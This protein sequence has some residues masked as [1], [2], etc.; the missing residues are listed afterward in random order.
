MDGGM[1]A[2][3]IDED[4][5]TDAGSAEAD[6]GE[7]CAPSTFGPSCA[8]V[9]CVHGTC[10]L[11][12]CW[13][14]AGDGTC[15][16]CEDGWLGDDCDQICTP[17]ETEACYDGPDGT[18][19]VGICRAGMRVCQ[20]SGKHWS[21]CFEQVKP[22]VEDICDND[23]DDNCSGSEADEVC[24]ASSG[25]AWVDGEHGSDASGNGSFASPFATL[26]TAVNSEKKLV[27]VMSD[28]DGTTYAESLSLG[29]SHQGITFVGWGP[30]RPTLVGTVEIIHCYD[31]AFENMEFAYPDVAN[32]DSVPAATVW[33]VHN[34]RSV[35]RNVRFSAPTG[36]PAGKNLYSTHH[37]YDATFLDVEVDDVVLAPG[38]GVVNASYALLDANDHGTGS[39]FTRVTLGSVSLSGPAPESLNIEFIRAWGYC[40]QQPD[41]VTAVRNALI[42]G[43]DMTGM[44]T[45]TTSFHAIRLGCYLSF[46]EA[47]GFMVLNNTFADI[48]AT[49]VTFA[50]LSLPESLQTWLSG[51]IVG[52]HTASAVTGLVS[53][54][55]AIID[56]S[57]FYGVTTPVSNA[58]VL[59]S[60]ML[61][62]DPGFVGAGDYRLGVGSPCIN[63]GDP[64]LTDG[65]STRSDMGAYGGPLAP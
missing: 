5:G 38:S 30:T 61:A 29:S 25:A 13:G 34:Y 17:F 2:G 37:G 4:S 50:T 3:S 6:A 53:N 14:S 11:G 35:F 42:T 41:G 51:N 32:D 18:E 47:A 65:D 9:T 39:Q 49:S 40:D 33:G 64:L 28:A 12:S 63:T 10:N 43:L 59:G 52:P 27:I 7:T 22:R 57:N 58:A 31:C 55:A 1:D 46:E 36:L 16:S 19:G 54:R 23:L 21:P 62:V 26:V 48:T 24:A 44:A 8:P 20:Q 60:N 45:S 56:H 15:D